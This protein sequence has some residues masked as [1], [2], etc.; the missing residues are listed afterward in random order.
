MTSDIYQHGG[1]AEYIS[2]LKRSPRFGPQVD[3]N[4]MPRSSNKSLNPG[5][6]QVTGERQAE[7]DRIGGAIYCLTCYFTIIIAVTKKGI[8][9]SFLE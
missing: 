3:G 6:G 5:V 8:K 1:V 9:I 4:L 2:S 7:Q